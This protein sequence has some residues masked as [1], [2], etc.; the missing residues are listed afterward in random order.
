M[1]NANVLCLDS[2]SV[3]CHRESVPGF[4]RQR[5]RL[6]HWQHLT[7]LKRLQFCHKK[8]QKWLCLKIW[9]GW[10]L[11]IAQW[12]F[13]VAY[14]QTKP[15]GTYGTYGQV[16][17]WSPISASSFHASA[18]VTFC[19]KDMLARLWKAHGHYDLVLNEW[20]SLLSEKRTGF[21]LAQYGSWN[22][23]GSM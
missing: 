1:E 10:I 14:F 13:G 9:Y 6:V 12:M 15:N 22:G 5:G 11:M 4:L 17:P 21:C 20:S 3:A 16:P 19:H 2:L 8:L 7:S 18:S 23:N